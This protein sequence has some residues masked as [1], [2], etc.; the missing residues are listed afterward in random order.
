MHLM[1][2][3]GVLLVLVAVLGSAGITFGVIP[4]FSGVITPLLAVIG[5]YLWIK[6]HGR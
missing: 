2:W 5:T 6:P 1:K 3:L 4:V